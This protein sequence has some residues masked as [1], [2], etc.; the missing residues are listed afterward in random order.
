MTALF[1]SKWMSNNGFKYS[2][3]RSTFGAYLRYVSERANQAEY[4]TTNFSYGYRR[5]IYEVNAVIQNPFL[6]PYTTPDVRSYSPLSIG[7][8]PATQYYITFG[9][10]F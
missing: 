9:L 7:S 5:G 3:N 2:L 8:N 6:E 4:V 1:S 10:N